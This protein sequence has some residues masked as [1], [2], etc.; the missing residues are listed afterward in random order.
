MIRIS[1][2]QLS[3]VILLTVTT[4]CGPFADPRAIITGDLQSPIYLG[5]RALSATVVEI[6]FHENVAATQSE[7]SCEPNLTLLG[8]SSEENVVTIDFADPMVPGDEYAV[9]GRVKDGAGNS[10]QFVTKL[11][12]FNPHVPLLQLSEFTT[13]GSGKHPDCVELVALTGGNLAGVTIYEGTSEDWS[14]RLVLPSV[15]VS[16]N[17]YIVV[18]FKPE[19]IDAEVN[20]TNSKTESGGYDANVSAWDFWVTD[21]NGLSGNNGVISIYSSPGGEI[22]DAVL[23]SDRTSSSD[24]QYGGFGSRRLVRQAELLVS[25]GAWRSTDGTARPE[26]AVSPES[27]TGTRSI[28]RRMGVDT[29][30]STDWYIVPT[31]GATFGGDNTTAVY[32]P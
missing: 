17:D 3:A 2:S 32:N 13:R 22:L 16:E 1:L 14:E 21:G 27:S 15:T 7:Y 25:S 4:G 26:D 10:M 9:S 31:R 11:F 29:N 12:G 18:H 30:S 19:G 8:V 20:E 6:D 23:Y 5:T 24:E 28:C